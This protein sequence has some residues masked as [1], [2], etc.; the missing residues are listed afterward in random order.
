MSVQATPA[1]MVELV[2]TNLIHLPASVLRDLMEL[3]VV[4]VSKNSP[5]LMY[6]RCHLDLVMQGN[7]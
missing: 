1:R 4:M 2:R 3:I 7:L 5:I 6:I